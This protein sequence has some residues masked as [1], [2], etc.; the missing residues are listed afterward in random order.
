MSD[1]PTILYS[2]PPN[3]FH[4]RSWSQSHDRWWLF[5]VPGNKVGGGAV[6]TVPHYG[7][8]QV[9]AVMNNFYGVR[10]LVKHILPHYEYGWDFF[11]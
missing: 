1:H 8:K 6:F 5:T 4:A 7:V 11:D 3:M 9:A 10:L 2:H